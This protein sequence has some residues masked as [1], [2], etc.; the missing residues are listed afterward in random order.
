SRRCGPASEACRDRM[1]QTLLTGLV[2]GRANGHDHPHGLVLDFGGIAAIALLQGL[3]E[4]TGRIVFYLFDLAADLQIAVLVV[5]ISNG[6]GYAR[7]RLEIAEV[8]ALVGVGQLEDTGL[9]VPQ[10]PHRVDPRRAVGGDR[11]EMS[12]ERPLEEIQV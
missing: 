12:E 8:V 4:G 1:W 5:R 3:I 2:A 9:S 7:V 11:G 10:E 6:Q